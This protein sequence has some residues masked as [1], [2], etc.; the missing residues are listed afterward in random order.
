MPTRTPTYV[1]TVTDTGM[2]ADRDTIAQR[3]GFSARTIRA[4]CQPIGYDAKTRRAIYD[5]LAVCDLMKERGYQPRPEKQGV[6]RPRRPYG[7]PRRPHRR[8]VLAEGL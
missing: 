6:P 3:T 1:A 8:V 4:Y 7:A 5:A 2:Y